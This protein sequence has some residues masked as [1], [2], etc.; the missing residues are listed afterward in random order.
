MSTRNIAFSIYRK[1]HPK[2]SQ[3]CSYGNFQERVRNSRG[4]RP[5][6]VR[7]TKVLLYSLNKN[8][9]RHKSDVELTILIKVIYNYENYT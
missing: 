2:L 1:N 6:S 8:C 5:I 9:S 3:I 4:K 7:A